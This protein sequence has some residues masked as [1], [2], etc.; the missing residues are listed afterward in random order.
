LEGEVEQG[1]RRR[2]R[3]WRR[4]W[5]WWWWREEAAVAG[6]RNR[7]LT[8]SL[9]AGRSGSGLAVIDVLTGQLFGH[10]VIQAVRLFVGATVG[11]GG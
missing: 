8:E 2:R 4:R 9:E 3:R 7:V 10:S 5:W 11:R 1:K 6:C